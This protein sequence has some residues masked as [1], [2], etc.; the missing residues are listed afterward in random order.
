MTCVSWVDAQDYAR[1]LSGKT[2][3][4][5]RLPTEAEW[6]RA[7]DGSQLGCELQ[8]P[9]PVHANGSNAAGLSHMVGNVWEW[10]ED[11]WEGDCWARVLRGGS[12]ADAADSRHPGARV[13]SKP[14]LRWD[15][16]GFRVTRKL[17]N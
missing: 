8:R 4:S 15:T 17:T 1:W 9:C 12:W 14:D 16:W 2:V 7:A 6:E 10:T 13:W 11:C 3:A 5:Y